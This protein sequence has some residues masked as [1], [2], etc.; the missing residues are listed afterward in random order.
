[1]N[2]SLRRLT[3]ILL[4]TLALAAPF[5]QADMLTAKPTTVDNV[6][7]IDAR[8]EPVNESTISAQTAGAV[9]RLH[10]DVND[11]VSQG[12]LLLE[13]DSTEQRA[14]VS[15]A[16]ANLAKA[17]AQNEDAQVLLK[18]NQRLYQQGTLSKGELDSTIATAKSTQAA[19]EAARA[20]LVRAQQQLSYTRVKAPYSGIVKAR[21]VEIGE[22][23]S[24]GQAL[25]S[26][27]APTP[28]RAVADI[29]QYLAQQVG[30]VTVETA[31]GSYPAVSTNVFPYADPQHH[32]VRLR[33]QLTED[34]ALMPG[35]W[36]KVAITSGQR[37]ALLVPASA[38]F[39]RGE[40]SAL[41]IATD[42]GT[43]LRQVRLGHIV[44]RDNAPWR[45]VLSGLS[46]GE[47]YHSD[48]YAHLAQQGGSQ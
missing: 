17:L 14:G 47:R 48:A 44:E 2:A 8:I 22:W 23:V 16:E 11:R 21:H 18:R 35:S 5:S 10:F 43:H 4:I 32:S 31:Q 1:M 9:V 6:V 13:I 37:E 7:R 27:F 25:M 34:T 36:A 24:P 28:L 38:I 20:G 30:R 19:V 26:G 33:A 12:D 29:P 41:F 42:T 15:Q 39:Q 46:A 40:I 45:E 3:P